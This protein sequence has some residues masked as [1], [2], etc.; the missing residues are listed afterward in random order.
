MVI[1]KQLSHYEPLERFC[2]E[3]HLPV[4]ERITYN[5]ELARRIAQNEV[6]AETVPEE[7][8]R[9]RALLDRIGG[10]V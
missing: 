1:N 4:L 10:A 6:V 8:R 9:F 2:E 3:H 5:E 7:K